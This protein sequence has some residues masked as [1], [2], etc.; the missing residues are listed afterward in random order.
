MRAREFGYTAAIPMRNFSE[1]LLFYNTTADRE[2]S[3]DKSLSSPETLGVG[4]QIQ[5]LKFHDLVNACPCTMID[6]FDNWSRLMSAGDNGGRLCPAAATVCS[7]RRCSGGNQTA[8]GSVLELGATQHP[9]AKG[10]QRHSTHW[11][12]SLAEFSI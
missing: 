10:H 4:H 9:D 11:L 3:E 12:T 2:I 7:D 6:K 8:S 5:T 1:E